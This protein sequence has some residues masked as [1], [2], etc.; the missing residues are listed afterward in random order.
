MSLEEWLST[1][2]FLPTPDEEVQFGAVSAWQDIQDNP[3]SINF[4][5]SAGVAVGAQTVRLESDNRPTE[6]KATSGQAPRRKVVVYGI[7][8]HPTLPDTNIKE[9]YTFNLVADPGDRYVV[10]DVYRNI[11]EVQA[12]AEATR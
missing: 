6:S 8:G 3:V 10:Q 12:I 1:K 9:G 7:Y 11:G 4:K 2:P 5:T